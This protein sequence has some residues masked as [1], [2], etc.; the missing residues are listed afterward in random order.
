LGE[1]SALRDPTTRAL[2]VASAATAPWRNLR[3]GSLGWWRHYDGGFGWVGPLFWP[4]AYDDIYDYAIWGY[5]P[6]FWDYGYEDVYAGLF[7]PYAYDEL[8]A[9]L[10][11]RPGEVTASL[12]ATKSTTAQLAQMC[13]EDKDIVDLPVDQ[14][15]QAMQLTDEQGAA[16]NDLAN[17]LTKAA[18]D[19]KAA[20]PTE[21]SLTAPD[22]FA[23]MRRRLEAMIAAVES[24]EPPLEKLYGLLSDEQKARFTALADEQRRHFVKTKLSGRLTA[25]CAAAQ[26]GTT[27]WPSAEIDRK[28]HPT[29]AQRA[30]LAA[31]QD[32]AAKAAN[33]IKASCEP[34]DALTPPARLAAVDK[35]LHTV[36][37][38]V[39]S[40]GSALN[41]FYSMLSDE[42]KAQFEAIGRERVAQRASL[43]E[44]RGRRTD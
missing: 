44:R 26:P 2:V 28:V 7:A 24:V 21:I 3:S 19:I 5:G 25:S 39:K 42:Q 1:A 13:G 8:T 40:V 32:A 12:G 31:L 20:C 22:R 35:R 18:Q 9:Y 34:D 41:H 10:P 37:D 23:A 15:R 43:R 17:A 4:F 16:L 38:A 14:F 36:L 27:E 11:G 30:S 29:E 33:L 6:A